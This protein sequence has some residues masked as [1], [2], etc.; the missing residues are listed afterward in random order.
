MNERV[1]LKALMAQLSVASVAQIYFSAM[2]CIR[3]Y[4]SLDL[5]NKLQLYTMQMY[6][7]AFMCFPN[8]HV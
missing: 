5:I 2:T 8:T 4:R 6:I 7:L 1:P 3:H